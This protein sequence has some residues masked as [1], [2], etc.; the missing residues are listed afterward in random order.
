MRRD[1]VAV[2]KF[3][4]VVA[5]FICVATPVNA[6]SKTCTWTGEAGDGLWR[7]AGNWDVRVPVDG[8]SVAFNN[9]KE[10]RIDLTGV[11]VSLLT[12]TIG[13]ENG[14]DSLRTHVSLVGGSLS[15]SSSVK[16]FNG[17]SLSVQG[18][19]FTVDGNI[20]VND[21]TRMLVGGGGSVAA[22]KIIVGADSIFEMNES[23]VVGRLCPKR[24][25]TV[26]MTPGSEFKTKGAEP[27]IAPPVIFD[28]T[29]GRY[30]V[31]RDTS[32]DKLMRCQ[33]F[34]GDYGFIDKLDEYV[35]E[36]PAGGEMF[37][38]N[39]A[40]I[41]KTSISWVD[42][43]VFRMKGGSVDV[44]VTNLIVNA[45]PSSGLARQIMVSPDST[46]CLNKSTDADVQFLCRNLVLGAG[47]VTILPVFPT[48]LAS[49]GAS[50]IDPTAVIRLE[51]DE[52]VLNG[53]SGSTFPV[54]FASSADR[55]LSPTQF[56]FSSQLSDGSSWR[57]ACVGPYAYLTD[58]KTPDSTESNTWTGK[59]G[60]ANWSTSGNWHESG[61]GNVPS[62]AGEKRTCINV[63]VDTASGKSFRFK[64]ACAAPF[65]IDSDCGKV[66]TLNRT[67]PSLGTTASSIYSGSRYPVVFRLP[68]TMTADDSPDIVFTV[69]SDGG[70]GQIGGAFGYVA[71][72]D[73]LRLGKRTFSF[74]GDVLVGA[75]AAVGSI[76]F[77]SPRL[78]DV[79][80][81]TTLHVV[82][83]GSMSVGMQSHNIE[84]KSSMVVEGGGSLVFADGAFT[85]STIENEHVVDGLLDIRA[86]FSGSVGIAFTGTGVVNIARAVAPSTGTSIVKFSGGVTLKVSEWETD[87]ITLAIPAGEIATLD[88]ES[89]AIGFPGNL[90]TVGRNAKLVKAGS[91]PLKFA[92]PVTVDGVVD[93]Q[94]GSIA[95]AGA[96]KEA[97][98]SG[99]VDV[100]TAADI[101]GT[102][103]VPEGYAFCVVENPEGG[104][105]VC[106]KRKKGLVFVVK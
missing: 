20:Y 91:G 71:F 63:D 43:A 7:S 82:E 11:K 102:V 42:E 98:T 61:P 19:A 50:S 99:Y 76:L 12:M 93:V 52:S 84:V 66:V 38:K 9:G 87:L 3:F 33:T 32:P 73:E 86:P 56:A 44:P 14:A 6:A 24:D 40:R 34:P 39:P 2:A 62:F 47:S 25:S 79:T 30:V 89:V 83:G 17:S 78:P 21:N 57:V 77:N 81:A 92:A 46:V 68:V 22:V 13:E 75:S 16:L 28:I 37:V 5:A 103:D 101:T 1:G 105:T 59:G 106:I 8:D 18:G 67:A 58:G 15:T 4:A 54:L 10:N 60:N 90:I 95:L 104:K 35:I 45:V 29:G 97:S 88:V 69:C 26:R 36:Y 70:D 55:D 65:I 31:G 80:R 48:L 23:K 74:C 94:S 72:M 27:E 53:N 85:Y 49:Y 96:L 41:D 64:P 51:V 100:L